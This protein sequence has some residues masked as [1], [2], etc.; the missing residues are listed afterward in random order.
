M[1][2]QCAIHVSHSTVN[3]SVHLVLCH[4][5]LVHCILLGICG[6]RQYLALCILLGRCG[7]GHPIHLVLCHLYL[8]HCIL[9][10][11]CGVR[12][13]LVLCIL[14]GRCGVGHPIHLVLQNQ[15]HGLGDTIWGGGN[16]I[17]GWGYFFTMSIY[18]SNLSL[19]SSSLCFIMYLWKLY[20][21][22]MSPVQILCTW[23]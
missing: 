5:Y 11:I 14:L 15:V 7:V 21:S 19:E 2:I 23:R 17:F 1:I 6:V 12:Q 20:G 10:G 4:L 16:N 22:N 18:T 3:M 9:L 13:H 8:V